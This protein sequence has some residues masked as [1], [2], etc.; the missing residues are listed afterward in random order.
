MKQ[1]LSALL[2][3]DVPLIAQAVKAVIATGVFISVSGLTGIGGAYS[4]IL[5][6]LLLHLI[7][8]GIIVAMEFGLGVTLLIVWKTVENYVSKMECDTNCAATLDSLVLDY[9]LPSAGLMLTIIIV[10]ATMMYS[11]IKLWYSLRETLKVIECLE[12]DMVAQNVQMRNVL[13]NDLNKGD[14][15][16]F[17]S[18]TSFLDCQR[19]KAMGPM[20]IPYSYYLKAKNLSPS[21]LEDL[22]KP[23]EDFFSCRIVSSAGQRN[24]KTDDLL[25]GSYY[26]DSNFF[27]VCYTINSRWSQPDKVLEKIRRSDKIEIEFFVNITD[28]NTNISMDTIT[29]PKYNY[30]SS[31]AIQL[32]LHHNDASLS[33]HRNGVELLGGKKYQL[34][35][36]QV[37]ADSLK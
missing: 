25:I 7:T 20:T 17:A 10:E 6:L 18:I 14:R 1:L 21:E 36:K 37:R 11:A 26:S 19:D 15:E 27:G 32:G 13:V 22:K 29:L 33:P 31:V 28:R 16:D 9:A 2:L 5:W 24:C 4:E 8:L 34:T 30:P 3:I 23:V 12:D 35:L